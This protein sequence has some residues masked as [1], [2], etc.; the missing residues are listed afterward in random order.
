[1][2]DQ[3]TQDS[4]L[5]P[6]KMVVCIGTVVLLGERVLFV[7]Q[8]AG[9]PLAGQWSIPRG[10]VDPA[11]S[12]EKAALRETYEES[13]ITAEIVGLLGVQNLRRPGW[14]AIVFL[15]HHRDGVP[16]SD[17]GVE[18]DGAAYFAL[19]EMEAFDEPFEP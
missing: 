10:I 2:A 3:K 13:G 9:H 1:M 15:C 6:P 19:A 18:T 5:W 8:A 4:A 12:P 16:V 7:R 17:G 14:L 11:E